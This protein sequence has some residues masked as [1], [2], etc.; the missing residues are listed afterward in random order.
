[1]NWSDR[2]GRVIAINSVDYPSCQKVK[3]VL[4][5]GDFSRA[6]ESIDEEGEEGGVRRLEDLSEDDFESG[7]DGVDVEAA[8]LK[9]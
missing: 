4:R 7:G 3:A 1:M 6:E 2:K 9:E 8:A 5:D